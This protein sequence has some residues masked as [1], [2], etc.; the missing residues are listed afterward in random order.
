[1]KISGKILLLF[2]A[3]L[4]FIACEKDKKGDDDPFDAKYSKLSVEDNKENIENA[5]IDMVSELSDLEDANAFAVLFHMEEL[6][7]GSGSAMASNTVLKPAMLLASFYQDK[8]NTGSVYSS[9]KSTAEDPE[10]LTDLWN[11]IKARYTWNFATESFDSTGSADD[12]IIEFPGMASDVS[13]TATLTIGDLE[14]FEVTDPR[15]DW[16]EELAEMPEGIEMELT[17][18]GDV[19]MTAQ[20]SA[21]YKSDGMPAEVSAVLTI[22][23]FKFGFNAKHT[24]YTNASVTFNL[25]RGS[26][27]LTEIHFDGQGDWSEESIEENVITYA[28]TQYY[29]Y[30]DYELGTWVETDIIEYVDEDTEIEIEE[31]IQNANAHLIFM[32]IKVAGKVNFKALGDAISEL[33]EDE[34]LTQREASDALVE[35]INENAQLVV[36]Y[37]DDN[38]KI[39]DA[40]AY[41]YNDYGDYYPMIRFVFAD[42]SKVD[43]TTYVQQELQSFIDELNAFISEINAD[44]GVEIEPVDTSDL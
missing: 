25:K 37:T 28:D 22:E 31:I 11:Q 29:E 16:P 40:E 24:P 42:E 3:L 23:D 27:L 36:V 34:T 20:F 1:M 17:Y 26:K 39:A 8:V 14:V 21:S 4:S 5:G 10:N 32:N 35:V 18:S 43:A 38:K 6:M 9:L 12:L 44:Y 2:V 30:Y 15:E 7:E 41:T 19:L 13:N 33:E